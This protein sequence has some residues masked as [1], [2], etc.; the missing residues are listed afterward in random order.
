MD[1]EL[2]S[3]VGSFESPLCGIDA[4]DVASSLY[5][6]PHDFEVYIDNDL[7]AL[8]HEAHSVMVDA[9]EKEESSCLIQAHMR[10]YLCRAALQDQMN[11][12]TTVQASLRGFLVRAALFDEFAAQ[13]LDLVTDPRF[14]ALHTWQLHAR[15]NARGQMLHWRGSDAWQERCLTDGFK[16]WAVNVAEQRTV[17]QDEVSRMY[18]AMRRRDEEARQLLVR[19]WRSGAKVRTSEQHVRSH[20]RARAHQHWEQRASRQGLDTWLN[21]AVGEILQGT[22]AAIEEKQTAAEAADEA[23]QDEVRLIR[24]FQSDLRDWSEGARELIQIASS[25]CASATSTPSKAAPSSFLFHR[26][27]PPSGDRPTDRTPSDWVARTP[28]ESSSPR[29]P[30]SPPFTQAPVVPRKWFHVDGSTDSTAWQVLEQEARRSPTDGLRSV[31]RETPTTAALRSAVWDVPLPRSAP[32]PPP[33][34]PPPSKEL[35]QIATATASA[36]YSHEEIEQIAEAVAAR[37]SLDAALSFPGPGVPTLLKS[38]ASVEDVPSASLPLRTSEV[39]V[40]LART[41]MPSA[42]THME[43]GSINSHLDA[44]SA[45][46]ASSARAVSPGTQRYEGHGANA[47]SEWLSTEWSDTPSPSRTG[48]SSPRWAVGS[49][50]AHESAPSPV[51]ATLEPSGEYLPPVL[52]QA[53]ATLEYLPPALT[54]RGVGR[55]PSERQLSASGHASSVGRRLAVEEQ[56]Q[57]DFLMRTERAYSA[58]VENSRILSADDMKRLATPSRFKGLS[59][60]SYAMGN[61]EAEDGIEAVGKAEDGI[62][63]HP[64]TEHGRAA[65][66]GRP[67]S[68]VSPSTPTLMTSVRLAGSRSPSPGRSR[69][70]SPD[71]RLPPPGPVAQPLARPN[72]TPDPSHAQSEPSQV[73]AA[74]AHVSSPRGFVSPRGFAGTPS[75]R[76]LSAAGSASSV[77]RRQQIEQQRQRELAEQEQRRQSAAAARS[78]TFSTERM[79]KMSAPKP[80]WTSPHLSGKTHASKPGALEARP[81][82]GATPRGPAAMAQAIAAYRAAMTPSSPRPTPAAPPV[83]IEFSPTST[84]AATPLNTSARFTSSAASYS[85]HGMMSPRSAHW[86]ASP[87]DIGQNMTIIGA[88]GS[89]RPVWTRQ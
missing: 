37:L 13:H 61:A 43:L 50:R 52:A 42:R 66:A 1:A 26:V 21:H 7:E 35:K 56:R 73:H 64:V 58:A 14:H 28:S 85:S 81:N 78:K 23:A 41:R 20:L 45:R 57:R 88:A 79:L 77:G 76:R 3:R 22:N 83:V 12:A 70:H 46:R 24:A 74:P 16:T 54:P 75:E 63:A 48:A 86:M 68:Y 53:Q 2:M 80:K 69:S 11:A 62:E 47:G 31:R 9:N 71:R 39:D 89:A 15:Y 51:P 38:S 40:P 55:T 49:A 4:D 32:P 5:E 67:S 10:G 34:P 30:S 59:I 19:R 72:Q 29:E 8:L 18:S 6:D 36:I 33:P 25:R 27:S 60:Y 44:S 87:R 17:A 82:D 65:V 84:C